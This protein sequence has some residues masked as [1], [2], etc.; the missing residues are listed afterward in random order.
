[1]RLPRIVFV[2]LAA[3]LEAAEKQFAGRTSAEGRC[4]TR[5][6][7]GEKQTVCMLDL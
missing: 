2:L 7:R 4:Y 6:L 3:K 5:D 1:V